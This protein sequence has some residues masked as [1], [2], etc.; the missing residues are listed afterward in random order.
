MD[1]PTASCKRCGGPVV[2]KSRARLAGVGGLM[3]LGLGLGW[4]GALLWVPAVILGLTGAFLLVWASVGQGR[5]C[6]QCKRFDGV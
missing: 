4:L 5:W 1:E 3:V 2:R 6:R